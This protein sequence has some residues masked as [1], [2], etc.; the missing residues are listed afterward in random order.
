MENLSMTKTD[1]LTFSLGKLLETSFNVNGD[2][3]KDI[4]PFMQLYT[5]RKQLL[6]LSV[7]TKENG[8]RDNDGV[9]EERSN[10]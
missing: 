1:Q 5:Y 3:L 4:C 10:M 2:T 9:S 7:Y 8:E 6:R